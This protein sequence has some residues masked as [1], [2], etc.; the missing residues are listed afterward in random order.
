[1]ALNN[2]MP[3]NADSQGAW[4]GSMRQSD[5]AMGDASKSDLK[6]GYFKPSDDDQIHDRYEDRNWNGTLDDDTG[7]GDNTGGIGFLL[8]PEPESTG[9]GFL[10][11]PGQHKYSNNYE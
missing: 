11:R 8:M 6:R 1:M 9:K 4:E 10:D 2:N 5:G 3:R 7:D